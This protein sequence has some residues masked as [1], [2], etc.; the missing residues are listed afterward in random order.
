MG[1]VTLR[2]IRLIYLC[3]FL[4]QSMTEALENQVKSKVTVKVRTFVLGSMAML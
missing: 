3:V 4:T 1:F 2:V